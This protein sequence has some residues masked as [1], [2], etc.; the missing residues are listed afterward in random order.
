MIIGVPKEIKVRE[1]RV[2]LAPASVRELVER[3]HS[4][5]V[6][7]QAGAGIGMSDEDYRQAGAEVVVS[8]DEV[9]ARS[10]MIVK[11]KEPQLVECQRLRPGQILFT[12][13]P[14]CV[15]HSFYYK[16]LDA[17]RIRDA[18]ELA[19]DQQAVRDQLGTDFCRRC[20][21]CAPC[22]VGIQ[23]PSVFLF[24]GYLQRYDLEQWARDRYS[25]LKVK[26]SACIG[27]GKCEP[28]CPYH[29]PIREKLKICAAD[30][31]E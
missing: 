17:R 29:L 14:E 13:L 20:N 5:L 19:E 27:C 23:I 31:G 11:V 3:G 9:F 22:S 28:R 26:A 8:A 10:E 21:Y 2:G 7:T 4:V 25:T 16:N 15:K 30:F 1:Y 6:E 12:Y 24:S 18:V